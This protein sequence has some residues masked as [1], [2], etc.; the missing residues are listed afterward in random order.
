MLCNEFVP[1]IDSTYKTFNQPKHRGIAGISSGGHLALLAAF[2]HPDIFLCAAGQSPTISKDLYEALQNLK[3]KGTKLSLFRIWID[4]GKYDLISG[5]MDDLT[6][7][8]AAEEFDKTLAKTGINHVFQIV[9]D[10]HQWASWRERTDQILI[11]FF[12]SQE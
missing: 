1:L 6:F 11:Y 2:R 9:D 3:E 8:Q 7:R 4:A 12:G 10:G 5:T